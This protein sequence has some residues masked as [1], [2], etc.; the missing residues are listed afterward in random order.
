MSVAK[1]LRLDDY[2]DRRTHRLRLAEALHRVE[3]LRH[4]VLSHLVQIAE[5]SGAD[6][7][8]TVW[9][10]EYGP[11][12]IHPHVVLDQLCDRPRRHF[13]LE[14]LHEAWELGVP[15]ALDRPPTSGLSIPSTFAVALGSDGIRAW[16]LIADSVFTRP[17]LDRG[18]RDRI[19][20]L[21]G[22]CASIVLHRDLDATAR[23]GSAGQASDFAGWPI[24]EDLEGRE[25]DEVASARI[26]RRFIVGRLVR[27]LVDDDLTVASERMVDQV[28][29][30]RSELLGVDPA[31]DEQ[32]ELTLWQSVLDSLEGGAHESL[33]TELVEL[34]DLIEAQGHAHGALELYRCAAAIA[35]AVGAPEVAADVAWRCGRTARRQADWDEARRWYSRSHEVAQAIGRGEL[36]ARALVGMAVVKKELGN[37]PAAREGLEAALQ[38]AE[39]SGHRDTVALVHHGLLGVEQALG[40][41]SRGLEHGWLAIAMYESRSG[42]L[43]CMASVAAALLECGDHETAEDAWTVVAHESTD[44]YYL[45]Y[46]HDALGHLSALQ[47][48]REGFARHSARCDALG[49]E[50]GA[51]SAKAEIS[52][53]RGL[54]YAALAEPEQAR[55]WLI[56]AVRI[57]EEGKYNQVLFKAEAALATIVEVAPAAPECP[58][59]T[60]APRELREGLRAMRRELVGASV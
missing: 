51:G 57:A 31:S 55:E 42:R 56:R 7:V 29:R 43:G 40:N 9:V 27:M 23:R 37:L 17:M 36:A 58:P 12:L 19:M 45:L 8:A 38:L 5:L 28:R 2:R 47:G 48:D 39:G 18:V 25:E 46:A 21:A 34:G 3:P 50:S 11:G 52:Y 33:A 6:R 13:S 26:A 30:A 35:A 20:F 4:A 54:S 16:F 53:H 15:G 32:A 24:L 1:V 60:T 59:A 41:V 14:P 49:W 22:E 10:D 44:R